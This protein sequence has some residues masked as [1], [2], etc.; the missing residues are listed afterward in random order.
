MDDR[1][2]C[3]E[4]PAVTQDV[5]KTIDDKF[6][7][8]QR[9]CQPEKLIILTEPVQVNDK[10]EREEQKQISASHNSVSRSDH[11]SKKMYDFNYQIY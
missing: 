3:L 11:C 6:E 8:E 4:I 2:R 7:V 5:P 1:L 9:K 10:H